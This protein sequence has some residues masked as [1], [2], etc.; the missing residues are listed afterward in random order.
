MS[1]AA[2]RAILCW[3][4]LLFPLI[5]AAVKRSARAMTPTSRTVVVRVGD[6]E[7]RT[8]RETLE[9]DGRGYFAAR[10]RHE[11]MMEMDFGRGEILPFINVDRDPEP[12]RNVLSW[13]RSHRLPS[14]VVA[15]KQALEDLESEAAFFALDG[16]CAAV[17]AA[18]AP[19]RRDASP[20]RA[21][22]ITTGTVLIAG[23]G[24]ELEQS[25]ILA[26]HEYCLISYVTAT[27]VSFNHP[28][29][30]HK[31]LCFVEER[32]EGSEEWKNVVP[33]VDFA[34]EIR[35]EGEGGLAKAKTFKA[36]RIVLASFVFKH[37]GHD[38]DPDIEEDGADKPSDALCTP[39]FSQCIRVILG[40]RGVHN[41]VSIPADSTK[42]VDTRLT[43]RDD[44]YE[45][46][47]GATWTLFG[48]VGPAAKVL[49]YARGSP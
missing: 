48:V 3:H 10:L 1:A 18:L 39:Q 19:L 17:S 14:A 30:F 49:E 15:D 47:N 35:A 16:L 21:F 8:T 29:M 2:A 23:K 40:P 37:V 26:P 25:L 27:T 9:Q 5:M 44:Q 7:F 36:S 41:P 20:L 38:Y 31:V 42:F 33:V 4:L 12:F 43:F 46:D 45:M 32:E 22:S 13:M 28:R 24:H 6:L 11:E 34:H